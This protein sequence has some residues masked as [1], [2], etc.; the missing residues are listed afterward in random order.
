MRLV[1]AMADGEAV[2]T[3]LLQ[4]GHQVLVHA[5]A[6]RFMPWRAGGAA[7][8][9]A[10]AVV[11]EDAAGEELARR[12]GVPA[13]RLEVEAGFLLDPF[14]PWPF[15][16]ARRNPPELALAPPDPP[17]PALL[18]DILLLRGA[19][20]AQVPR[21]MAAGR[22]MVAPRDAAGGL[23]HEETALLYAPPDPAPQLARLVADAALCARLGA[24]AR[25]AFERR[26]AA[27][28]AA[29]GAALRALAP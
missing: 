17:G 16:P 9:R 24:A 7:A 1:L 22:A 10:N 6:S 25:R 23:V 28:R 4:D 13:V 3:A 18:P 11:V 8:F 15:G 14:P 29:L 27:A 19:A 5:P 2:R 12:L 26:H 20:L 21:W